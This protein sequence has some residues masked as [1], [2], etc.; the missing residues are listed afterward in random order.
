M[1]LPRSEPAMPN[2][3]KLKS[4]ASDQDGAPRPR[5]G[6]EQ[7]DADCKL[8]ERQETQLQGGD[9]TAARAQ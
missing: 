7:C 6:Y 9:P 1:L 5:R 2:A 3:A 4:E 8:N